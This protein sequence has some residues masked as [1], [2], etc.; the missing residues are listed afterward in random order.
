MPF[1]ENIPP[2]QIHRQVPAEVVEEK[3]AEAQERPETFRARL[4]RWRERWDEM[5]TPE[6]GALAFDVFDLFT[7]GL[8]DVVVRVLRTFFVWYVGLLLGGWA[9]LWSQ[10]SPRS[11]SSWPTPLAF[12]RAVDST[13]DVAAFAYA[14]LGLWI[15]SLFACV[16]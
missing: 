8:T 2:P 14:P 6:H 15:Y 1:P 11:F 12:A 10:A 7:T 5:T 13:Q 16:Y 4:Q 9:F 3:R